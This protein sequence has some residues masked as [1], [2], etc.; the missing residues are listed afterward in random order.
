MV[1]RLKAAPTAAWVWA[2]TAYSWTV[3]TISAAWFAR[4]LAAGRGESLSVAA[5]LLWQG[6]IYAAWLPAAG[7]VWLVLRRFGAGARGIAA[8]FL[9][10]LAVVPLETLTAGLIDRAFIGGEAALGARML[11]RTPVCLLLYSAIVA[12][13]LAAA[14]HRRAR[15][16]RA[17]NA[18]LE[19][20]LAQARAVVV[21]PQGAERLM[22]MSGARRIPV[23]V[24]AVEWFGAAD[25]YVVV[26]WAGRE[27]LLRATLQSLEA[28]LDPRLFARAH[29]S[30]LVNLAHVREAR[31]LS[32]GSWRLTMAGGDEVVTSRTY[33]DALLERLGA[34]L[35][36][37]SRP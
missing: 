12:V 10:G 27:G 19:A 14:H 32:D 8:N 30:S 3:T 24:S 36:S 17:R 34:P 15:E 33:R 1:A 35:T 7:V 23:E 37:S 5:S 18:L 6:G 22:V 13:G 29:R 31:P 25:N 20:A 26:H 9:A 21:P 11:E 16:A 4:R 2:F 28:K